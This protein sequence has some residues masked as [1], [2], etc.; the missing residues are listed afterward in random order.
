[1]ATVGEG[2]VEV[3]GVR[4]AYLEDGPVD[5]P[6]ALC[7]HGF[8]DSAHTWRHLLPVLAD[9]GYHGVAPFLRGYAP[10]ELAT[11]G[12]YQTGALAADAADLHQKL[13]GGDDAV[14][15][16]HDWG[17]LA[18]YAAV[19]HEPAR[20]RRAVTAAVPPV[21]AV[22]ETFFTY[23]QLKRSWYTF[24][25]QSPLA[26]IALPI[27]EYAFLDH[28]WAEW[29]PGYDASWDLARVKESIGDP[30]RIVAAISYYRAM[31]DPEHRDPALAP[32]EDAAMAS[33]R[34]PTL[35]L[36]GAD[37]GCFAAEAIGDPLAHLGEGSE[38]VTIEGAGHFLQLEQPEQV[39]GHILRFLAS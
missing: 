15:I 39:N 5:G 31:Y 8:P 3:N 14:L 28:L 10:T 13:G 2:T 32:W 26:E 17:A 4:Y 33:T 24:F 35:Y 30:V 11:D 6:L 1:L 7:L 38:L 20:W 27:D 18:T 22:A 16:G 21:P 36:H 25:F 12:V 37:D 9:A 23:G 19:G 29:S 34:I